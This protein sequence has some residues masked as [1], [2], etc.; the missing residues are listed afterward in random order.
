M[1]RVDRDEVYGAWAPDESAWSDWVKSVVFASLPDEVAPI[2]PENSEEWAKIAC[3][4]AGDFAVVV[5]LPGPD[6][7]LLGVALA[8]VGYRAVPLYNA[9]PHP[10]AF[11]DL[12]GV[13]QALVDGAMQLPALPPTAPPAFLVDESRMTAPS[14]PSRVVAY[15]NRSVVR[16]TDFPT[17]RKLASAGI[18]RALLIRSTLER[19]APDLEAVLLEWQQQGLEL[20]QLAARD[21]RPPQ[22][23]RLAPRPW[24]VRAWAWLSGVSPRRRADGA[25]GR[26]WAHGS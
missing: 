15:D 4:C 10:R 23:L 7:V 13:M 1:I 9:L 21:A 18:R 6:G 12:E 2:A 22:P 8:H 26:F 20:W 3:R 11:V 24:Y 17:P 5:D 14:A 25:Y 16:G 19:P